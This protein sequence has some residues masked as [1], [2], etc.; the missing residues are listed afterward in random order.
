MEPL[1][2]A[3]DHF[4]R[5]DE[6]WV[7]HNLNTMKSPPYLGQGIRLSLAPQMLFS[8]S[9][10]SRSPVGTIVACKKPIFHPFL[11]CRNQSSSILFL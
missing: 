11:L 7:K 3:L 8:P 4:S 6:L 1:I 9:A 10:T 5:N 2:E